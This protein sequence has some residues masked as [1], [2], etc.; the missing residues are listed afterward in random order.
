MNFL[1]ACHALADYEGDVT[2]TDMFT[3]GE[4]IYKVV[5]RN[6]VFYCGQ[7]DICRFV[8]AEEAERISSLY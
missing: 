2:M 4:R 5:Y 6:L 8:A 3:G 1:K 7:R